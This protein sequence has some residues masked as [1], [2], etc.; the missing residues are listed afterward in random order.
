MTE[1]FRQL[2][3]REQFILGVAALLA[4]VII[5]WSFVWNPLTA[6]VGNLGESVDDRSRLVVDLK[7]AGSLRSTTAPQAGVGGSQGLVSLIDQTARSLGLASAVEN[8][9]P[10]PSG[11]EIRITLRNAAFT[12]LVDWLIVLDH[13]HAL[14]VSEIN[15]QPAPAGPG[16]VR[17]TL[18]LVRS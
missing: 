16:L 4:V 7:R 18:T 2:A 1:W 15:L 5:G 6:A 13:D 9:I 8:S 17:G 12:T 14:R 3:P 11:A 10:D